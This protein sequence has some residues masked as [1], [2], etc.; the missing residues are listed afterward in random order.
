[1]GKNMGK[2]APDKSRERD[3]F[4]WLAAAAL[5]GAALLYA[6]RARPGAGR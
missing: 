1:M 3:T 4:L 6:L 5:L 2:G